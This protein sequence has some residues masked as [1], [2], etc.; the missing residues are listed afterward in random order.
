MTAQ[1]KEQARKA[2]NEYQRRWRH[3]NP[4]RVKQ[5]NERYWQRRFTKMGA[6][7]GTEDDKR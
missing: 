2:R 3:S 4:E 6:I 5:I 1:E 7:G